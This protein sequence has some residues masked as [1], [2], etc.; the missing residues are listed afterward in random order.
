M[1][2]SAGEL[3]REGMRLFR[4][5]TEPGYYIRRLEDGGQQEVSGALFGPRNSWRRPVMRM[6]MNI[7]GALHRADLLR[8]EAAYVPARG[9]KSVQDCYVISAAGEA[10]WRRQ[11]GG[12][13]PFR[14]QHQL[15]GER[16]IDEQGRGVV[17]RQVNLGETPLGWLRKRKGP[18]GTAFL[19]DVEVEAGEHLRRDYTLAGLSARV[20]ADWSAM[21]AHV[22]QSRSGPSSGADIPLAAL[23]ARRRVECALASVGPGLADV[24]IETCCHLT[25]L[26]QAEQLLGWPQR[27]AKIVLKIALLR[28]ANHYGHG[29]TGAEKRGPRVWR[30]GEDGEHLVGG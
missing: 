23:D 1:E 12:A 13:E 3:R 6:D 2:I 14:A 27:S 26:E 4:R 18:D 7:V 9:A 28:L 5:L 30:F 17:R 25:G 16:A 10:W 19:S 24:L 29:L 20:T 11:A 15:M 22:D 21:A 8:R